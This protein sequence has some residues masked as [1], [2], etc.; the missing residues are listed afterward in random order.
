M[1][2]TLFGVA[3]VAAF[4]NHYN[5]PL[6]TSS[7]E[8]FANALVKT[9]PAVKAKAEADFEAN[10]LP[11]IKEAVKD[12]DQDFRT[13]IARASANFNR[14]EQAKTVEIVEA[15]PTYYLSSNPNTTF[16]YCYHLEGGMSACYGEPRVDM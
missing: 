7:P 15:K 16:K 9:A 14:A 3:L 12:F 1:L 8:T 4:W 2:K 10:A 13:D 6:D 5:E 11:K